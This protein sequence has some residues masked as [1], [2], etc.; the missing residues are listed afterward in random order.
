[1]KPSAK[2]STPTSKDRLPTLP[3]LVSVAAMLL[4]LSPFKSAAQNVATDQDIRAMREVVDRHAPRAA[5]ARGSEPP[6]STPLSG[7]T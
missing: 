1:M 3:Y 2:R 4:T 5:S 7:S 6:S